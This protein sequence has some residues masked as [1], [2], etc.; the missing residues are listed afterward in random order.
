MN[1]DSTHQNI[2]NAE[3][4]YKR[5]VS[6][7]ENLEVLKGASISLNAGDMAVLLGDSGTGKSTF[8]HI[9]GTLDKPNDGRVMYKGVDVTAFDTRSLAEF[10]NRRVGFVYQFHHLL[11]EFT[12]AENVMMPGLI[13]GMDKNSAASRA[14]ELLNEVGLRERM[15]H[16]PHQLSGGE[17]QRVA[18][19]RAL[20]NKPEVIYADEPTGNLDMKTGD[21]LMELFEKLNEAM[22]QTFLIATHNQR[23]SDRAVRRF[24]IEGGVI[25]SLA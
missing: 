23:L 16:H 1:M 19:A 3:N 25:E 20:F 7:G 8:L 9:L 11:P 24:L 4:I 22:S 18:I 14:E 17:A 21:R 2:L 12:A 13:Y 6:E 5:Y 10:R 15:T